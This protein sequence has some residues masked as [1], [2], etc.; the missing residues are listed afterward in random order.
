MTADRRKWVAFAVVG[1]ATTLADQLSKWRARSTLP[2]TPDGCAVPDDMVDGRCVGVPV[3]VI[4]DLWDWRLSMNPGAAFGVFSGQAGARVFLS[5]VAVVAVAVMVY[6]VHRFI[7]WRYQE[8]DSGIAPEDQL[9][10]HSNMRLNVKARRSRA[11][12]GEACAVPCFKESLVNRLRSALPDDEVVEETRRTFAALADR[13]RI[14][15]LHA[16]KSDEE[17][18]VCDLAHVLGMSVSATSHHLRKLRDL[19]ILKHR[20][21]GKMTYYS[22]RDGFAA[23]LVAKALRRAA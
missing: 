13:T 9:R 4:S 22:L 8:P 5:I 14:R 12:P 6:M 16:L 18:C 23:E 19:K 15:L 20:D 10:H 7:V 3:S 21:D 11:T 2:V 17:L 1:V